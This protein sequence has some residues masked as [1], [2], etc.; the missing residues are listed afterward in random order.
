MEQK[1]SLFKAM[2]MY[3]PRAGGQVG[4]RELM[5]EMS[6]NVKNNFPYPLMTNWLCNAK[7]NYKCF[8][9]ALTDENYRQ[10]ERELGTGEAKQLIDKVV[11]SGIKAF[12]ING[13]EPLLRED[14]FELIEYANS[15]DLEVS[16]SSNMSLMTE[17]VLQKLKKAG[18]YNIIVSLDASTKE[19][20]SR[21]KGV[22][23][24][25]TV[26]GNIKRAA[27][28]G[29]QITATMGVTKDNEDEF[30][31]FVYLCIE[32]NVSTALIWMPIA[33]R[34]KDIG[35]VLNARER[36]EFFE[37]I[38][39]LSKELYD[40]IALLGHPCDGQ[41]L[42]TL[43]RLS[44]KNIM[45]HLKFKMISN[46]SKGCQASTY[47]VGLSLEG[48]IFPCGATMGDKGESVGN[49]FKDG[50][51]NVWQNSDTMLKIR[52]RELKGK[53]NDCKQKKICGGCRVVAW[54]STGDY[55]ESDPTCIHALD[56]PLDTEGL[57]V[58]V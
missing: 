22:D 12:I 46:M 7:C 51:L 36:F 8:Y 30:E 35:R 2:F 24:F 58:R 56:D 31:K 17:E 20:Y 16:V 38:Y 13:G 6:G 48:N 41:W 42:L 3:R 26:L 57:C 4:T 33:S 55:L 25:D 47:V 27:G 54:L 40:R 10:K 9:C 45:E 5:T 29:F 18:L 21:S 43:L 44:K 49:I 28:M 39:H 32:H 23:L 34:E 53:C 1:L 11:E 52:N 14:I 37:K 19:T 15:K 50:L